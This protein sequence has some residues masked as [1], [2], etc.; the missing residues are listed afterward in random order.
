VKKLFGTDGIRGKANE[1][2]I[3][4][5]LV[6]KLGQAIGYYFKGAHQ[7][8]RVLIGKDTRRSGYMLEQA[9]SAGICSV[10]CDAYVLGPLPTPGIAYLTRGMRATAGIVISASHNPFSDNGIK[11]F[12]ANGYKLPDDIEE[13]IESLIESNLMVD[14]LPTGAKIGRARRV[15]DAIGQYAV[16]LKEQF[17]K[18]LTLDGLRIIL[19]CANGAAYKVA[20][21][22]FTELGAECFL[23]GVSP[24]GTNIND[25]CGALHP[26]KMAEQVKLYKADIGL[27]FDGD[28]DRL[29]IVDDTG[30][31]VDGDEIL[32]ICGTRMMKKGK[33][34]KNT[35]VST[36]MSNMGLD[37]AMDRVSA[38]VVRTKVG[39]RYVMEE[40]L[41][42]DFNLGG[43][44]SGHLIF[45]DSAT[46]GDGI[47]A[48]LHMLEIMIEEG[49]KVSELKKC[50]ERLPQVLKNVHVK[51][52][53]PLEKLPSLQESIHK[54]EQ[55]LGKS[56]RIL[57]RYSGTESVVRI[58]VEGPSIDLIDKLADE[59][60]AETQT[61]MAAFQGSVQ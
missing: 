11:I 43:E 55:K 25:Q 42:G 21:K 53:I 18:H 14:H 13:K 3:S 56:G 4:I 51:E 45:R 48:A 5:E 41:K 60:C 8:P 29:V 27:A 44:Q 31:I 35:I 24:D 33:L 6:T 54:K 61:A 10:G 23:I 57:F 40:M 32:A 26:G 34:K 37:I 17:P 58:M 49:K 20:P 9:L 12:S 30:A 7:Q 50:L 59:L 52:K 15:E 39:D 46:T 16:Y 1:Y 22:V 19:D 28:A 47:L 2:P 38:K 36:I